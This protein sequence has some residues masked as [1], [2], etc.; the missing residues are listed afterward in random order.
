MPPARR[1]AAARLAAA[2][3]ALRDM[4][5]DAW[6]ASEDAKIGYPALAVKDIE[7]GKVDPFDPL[8]G[9]D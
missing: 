4:I 6:I 2:V 7:A 5:A 8:R 9:E 1:L 3:T